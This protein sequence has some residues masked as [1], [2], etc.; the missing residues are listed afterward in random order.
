MTT[1][2]SFA[3]DDG[4]EEDV[5]LGADP[6]PASNKRGTRNP[7][8]AKDLSLTKIDPPRNNMLAI[9]ILG[10]SFPRHGHTFNRPYDKFHEVSQ[11]P[12]GHDPHKDDGDV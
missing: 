11:Y 9:P 3:E 7:I 5:E 10:M 12:D 2:G 6:H 8:G 1:V 4:P